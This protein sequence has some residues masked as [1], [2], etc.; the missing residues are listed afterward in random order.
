MSNNDDGWVT[1]STTT[2]KSNKQ[3]DDNNN[4]KPAAPPKVKTNTWTADFS[5]E[6]FQRQLEAQDQEIEKVGKII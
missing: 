3:N 4:S 6:D 5:I 1:L 2:T